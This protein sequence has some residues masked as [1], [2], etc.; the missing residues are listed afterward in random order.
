MFRR[1]QTRL[2]VLYAALFG[3]VLLAVAVAVLWVTTAQARQQG[4]SALSAVGETFDRLWEARAE[5]LRT[6]ATLLSR[7]YGFRQALATHDVPTIASAVE[8]L[9]GR[10]GLDMA[11]VVDPD[12][13][14]V[15]G[16]EGTATA[17]AAATLAPALQG[18]GDGRGAATVGGDPYETVAAPIFAPDLKG[19]IVF[20]V[21]LDAAEMRQLT[22]LSPLPLQA[23]VVRRA[24]SRWVPIARAPSAAR[25]PVAGRSG[26]EE[27]S[28]V[29]PLSA[30]E[31]ELQPA[32]RL[33]Y[34][35][36]AA[37]APY[38]RLLW[39]LAAVGS[40]G[41]VLVLVGGWVLA[42]SI[43]RP[44]KLLSTAAGRLQTDASARV[45]LASRDEI[46]DLARGFNAM[47]DAIEEREA[48]LI[49]AASTDA[50]TGLP[51]RAALES[52][53]ADLALGG[54]VAVAAFGVER[55]A[56]MR[57]ALGFDLSEALL[58]ELG[59]RLHAMDGAWKVA[60]TSADTLAVV[61]A[62]P[63]AV[64]ARARVEAARLH[65]QE[66]Q[67]VGEHLIDVRV[68]AGVSSG[69]DPV[70]LLREA[71]L[72]LDTAR[73]GDLATAVFDPATRRRAA[74]SLGLMPALR[75]AI[76]EDALQLMHQPKRNLRQGT[77]T[78]VESLVRW[79]H[80][81]LGPQRPDLFIPLAE[82]TGDIRAV[83]EWVAERAVADQREL[84]E[85]GHRLSFAI[86]LSGRL[87]GDADMT[88]RL[89]SLA[90]RAAGPLCVEVTETAVIG[91]PQAA[92]ATFAQL[93][94]AGVTVAIDDYGSGLSSLA[95]L[96]QIAADELKL[97]RSLVCDLARSARDALLVRSTIDLAHGLGMSVTAEGVEDE[98]TLAVLTGLGCDT[99]QGWVFAKAMPLAALAD[100]LDA[101]RAEDEA[102]ALCA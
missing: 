72:A 36:Q 1:L 59:G 63:D 15:S 57:G 64:G 67:T 29:R 71:D 86:N 102:R 7:D 73:A 28:L 30:S 25:A 4:A 42:R 33:T 98:T 55:F 97:D 89:L 83:T 12:G 41:L 70:Q 56:R 11:Y 40:I 18:G 84:A 52:R 23:E 85:R 17:Q 65:L 94:E 80:P 75:R 32:L 10:L 54:R 69:E 66:P 34:P 95:Y 2:T 92:L 91:C 78:S 46:G 60:R 47:A 53:V 5:R 6:G 24:G 37:L 77:T 13:R 48:R 31:P 20:A 88:R 50:A 22:R 43:T 74:E 96:K 39:L 81:K 26:D 44:L 93:R 16:G 49:E 62:A 19:W 61:F 35:L 21:R 51:N 90:A 3:A 58:R 14:L 101:E 100:R 99:V 79:T 8:N 38:R 87:V 82:E 76:R 45:T 27:L 68:A 9:R